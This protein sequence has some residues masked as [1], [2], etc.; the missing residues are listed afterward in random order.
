MLSPA[1]V[2]AVSFSPPTPGSFSL[3]PPVY[4]KPYSFCL[5]R[6]EGHNKDN[7]IRR[8]QALIKKI[9]IV[10]HEAKVMLILKKNS[11]SEYH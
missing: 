11:S 1:P 7:F 9:P 6:D 4:N 5:M 2:P 3:S 8:M 10:N